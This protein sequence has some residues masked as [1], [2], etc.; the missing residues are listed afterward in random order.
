MTAAKLSASGTPQNGGLPVGSQRS[1]KI[2]P[3]HLDRLAIVYVRQSTAQQVAANRESADRQ[4]GLAR[5][6]ADL[7]WPEDRIIVID[8]DQGRSGSSA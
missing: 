3:R 8:D 2:Q 7:G 1:A 5:R 4:Y 6:A